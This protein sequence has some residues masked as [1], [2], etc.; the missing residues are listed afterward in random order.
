M[1]GRATARHLHGKIERA[2]EQVSAR[3]ALSGCRGRLVRKH[4]PGSGT[5]ADGRNRYMWTRGDTCLT[6]Y[7]PYDPIVMAHAL[8]ELRR[9]YG[10]VA[11]HEHESSF[12]CI[13][14]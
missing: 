8:A 12:K 1:S 5:G 7:D 14:A 9:L 3:S 6:P 13:W 11:R 10:I 4:I 2:G